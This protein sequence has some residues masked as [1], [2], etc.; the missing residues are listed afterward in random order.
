M[1]ASEPSPRDDTPQLSWPGRV[2]GLVLVLVI[3]VFTVPVH[4]LVLAWQVVSRA[5]TRLR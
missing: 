3:V 5:L 2:A 1:S 4:A